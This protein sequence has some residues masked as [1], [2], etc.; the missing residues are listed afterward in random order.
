MARQGG[1]SRRGFLK[2]AAA[3]V[4]APYVLTSSA[5]GGPVGLAGRR[6]GP[7]G[8]AGRRGG[9][10]GLAG[11]RG[12]PD[13]EAA[14]NRVVMGCI[15]VGR[16]GMEDLRGFLG[17]TQIVAVCD[18]DA[19]R[20]ARAK[21]EVEKH[22][23]SRLR[24]RATAGAAP[25]PGGEYKGCAAYGDFRDLVARDDIDAV[26]VV[27]PD[28]WHVIA[29]LEACRHGKDV[30]VEK[31]LSLTIRE[32]QA[33]VE[34]VRRYGRVLQVGSQ[35]RSD[36]QFRF[37]CELVR[38]GRI[39]RV[40][41]VRVGLPTDPSASPAAEAGPGTTVQPAGSTDREVWRPV[42]P[43]PEGLD[44]D[45]WLGPAPWAPYTVER[46]HPQKGYGRPGWLRISDYSGGMM[47]GWGSHHIDIA[48][49]GLGTERT[50]PI[51]IEGRGE[52]PSDGL[53]D[54]HGK[55][56]VECR[57]ADGIR[58]IID[59]GPNGVRFEGTEGWVFVTRGSMDAE[60]KSLLKARLGPEEVHLVKS[61]NHQENFIACV[62]SRQDPV[63]NVEVGHRSATICHLGNIA[64]LTGRKIK[65]D[66]DKE[67]IVG[68]AEA[69][70][71]LDR[72][73]REPWRI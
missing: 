64:M 72:P 68:D 44:Y 24:Q 20:A 43:V 18:V 12:G 3:A 70:R 13:E 54:V 5:L 14:S 10:V 49:W 73:K 23:A 33:V 37:A 8:L 60:P 22:Y 17:R 15:G 62:R 66:P 35:Q 48:Q 2:V 65:W 40:Q 9:P 39:G 52:F 50:G 57:Y 26:L 67:Q 21:E 42:M 55:F 38:N 25:R 45:F 7:V 4:A 19:N 51:E 6:G 34:A 11:R 58:M 69:S 61:V 71:W 1:V 28:H 59:D 56:R 46:V 47:T 29:T 36:A 16:M 41:T 63:A 53:W 27:T 32:G 30:Y 31:P